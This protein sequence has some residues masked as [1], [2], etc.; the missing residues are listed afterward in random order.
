MAERRA[1]RWRWRGRRLLARRTGAEAA[2]G[3]V[4]CRGFFLSSRPISARPAA[5]SAL[6]TFSPELSMS[7]SNVH[8]A[9]AFCMAPPPPPFLPL[10]RPPSNAGS[11]ARRSSPPPADLHFTDLS[12]VQFLGAAPSPRRGGVPERSD[13][14]ITWAASASTAPSLRRSS[15]TRTRNLTGSSAWSTTTTPR[16]A[17]APSRRRAPRGVA[18]CSSGSAARAVDRPALAAAA[19][20]PARGEPA[21]ASST[22]SASRS[23]AHETINRNM[24]A[25]QQPGALSDVGRTSPT[26]SCCTPTPSSAARAGHAARRRAAA[27]RR[28]LRPAAAPRDVGGLVDGARAPRRDSVGAHAQAALRVHHQRATPTSRCAPTP[29][30]EP[31]SRGA[32][33]RSIYA[34]NSAAQFCTASHGAHATATGFPG[35]R[36]CRS[37][38]GSATAAYSMPKFRKFCWT[39]CA[40]GA[41]FVVATEAGERADAMK[42]LGKRKPA[43]SRTAR[44]CTAR[45]R[46]SARTQTCR[47]SSTAR[48]GRRS[49]ARWSNTWYVTR[50]PRRCSPRWSTR[51]CRRGDAADHRRQLALPQHDH[52]PPPLHRVATVPRRRQQVLGERGPQFHGGPMVLNATLAPRR[53]SR[54][55]RCSRGRWI[56]PSTRTTCCRCGTGGWPPRWSPE[57]RRGPAGHRRQFTQGRSDVVQGAAAAHQARQRRR[58]RHAGSGTGTRADPAQR[59]AEAVR[60]RP[61]PRRSRR[62]RQR[63]RPGRARSWRGRARRPHH[64]ELHSTGAGFVI[65]FIVLILVVGAVFV[66]AVCCRTPRP[67]T[68]RRA[69]CFQVIR[70][71]RARGGFRSR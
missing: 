3:F 60:S 49:T 51:C 13:C 70:P 26:C 33:P 5:S 58:R 32:P 30:Y 34:R 29:R 46:S 22:S 25:L 1:A 52:R 17:A 71:P 9:A 69:G 27:A 12:R 18:C 56:R 15:S 67:H 4:F 43:W 40:R 7:M 8:G 65:V 21:V 66:A 59:I 68:R 19:R 42:V 35:G 53:R 37:C 45:C 10:L 24:M 64:S 50:S 38:G 14:S 2:A 54:R 55:V 47:T 41:A 57:E 48:S 23:Y 11:T 31:S 20:R 16:S 39:E 6:L 63:P 61:R 28:L 62:P 44:S 36:S